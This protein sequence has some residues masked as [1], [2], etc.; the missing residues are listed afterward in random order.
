M[1]KGIVLFLIFVFS[2]LLLSCNKEEPDEPK[3]DEHD[4]TIE[5]HWSMDDEYHWHELTCEHRGELVY[6]KIHH[7]YGREDQYGN[8]KC[9]ICGYEKKKEFDIHY[10]APGYDNFDI[11][12]SSVEIYVG[13]IFKFQYE[14]RV[15]YS[16][17]ISFRAEDGTIV[18]INGNTIKGLSVGETIVYPYYKS[19]KLSQFPI[20]VKVLDYVVDT[21]DNLSSDIYNLNNL[22]NSLTEGK[23]YF[24]VDIE[25]NVPYSD[26]INKNFKMIKDPF[27]YYCESK[28]IS[29]GNKIY[30]IYQEEDGIEY[31]YY[32]IVGPEIRRSVAHKDTFSFDETF[33]N[34]F[35]YFDSKT[36]EIKYNDGKYYIKGYSKDLPED[37]QHD[38]YHELNAGNKYLGRFNGVVEVVGNKLSFLMNYWFI[39]YA[40]NRKNYEVSYSVDVTPFEKYDLSAFYDKTPTSVYEVTKETNVGS[41]IIF[42]EDSRQSFNKTYFEEGL[43]YLEIESN[44]PRPNYHYFDILLYDNNYYGL[45]DKVKEFQVDGAELKLMFKI[46]KAGYYYYEVR[47]RLLSTETLKIVKYNGV[48]HDE[49][50]LGQNTGAITSQYDH[51]VFHQKLSQITNYKITN[52]GEKSVYVYSDKGFM[53]IKSGG[54]ATFSLFGNPYNVKDNYLYLVS[55][56]LNKNSDNSYNFDINIEIVNE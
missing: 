9:L 10:Q 32:H 43:Y 14:N 20:N 47:N 17:I 40:G 39:D 30:D 46:P 18:E 55:P 38:L 51:Y 1:K 44:Y 12:T 25:Y 19:L 31:Y 2:F 34:G 53:E 26:E 28:Y 37:I 41:D 16:T 49:L 15:D 29:Y 24:T 33:I 36:M 48:A 35:I 6:D 22:Y 11:T 5:D 4:H 8:V 27:Y 52:N 42:L 7:F 54:S 13:E 56:F 23:N 3:S 21:R 50:K 45:T